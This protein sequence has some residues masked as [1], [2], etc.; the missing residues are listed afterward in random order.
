MKENNTIKCKKCQGD[1][2]NDSNCPK[3]S[4]NHVTITCFK[5]TKW[6]AKGGSVTFPGCKTVTA[7]GNQ[8][9]HCLEHCAQYQ[10]MNP[11]QRSD[12]V[13]SANW[14]PVHLS[15][16]H[17][18]SKC[19]QRTDSKVC[20]VN[21]CDKHHHRSLHGSTTQFVVSVNTVSS[22]QVHTTLNQ[23]DACS[24]TGNVL[25]HLENNIYCTY[26][27]LILFFIF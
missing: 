15:Y 26:F 6:V 27:L 7:E 11:D 5:C 19:T 12:C 23:S 24:S 10:A 21:G 13:Q 25:A 14:C 3:H 2:H 4:V 16:S 22:A 9:G 1:G 20:G 8:L 18:L 17:D